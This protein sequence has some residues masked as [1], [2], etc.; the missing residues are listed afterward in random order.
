V[1]VVLVVIVVTDLVLDLDLVL[2]LDDGAR[3]P[4]PLDHSPASDGRRGFFS[5]GLG[6]MKAPSDFLLVSKSL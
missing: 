6:T 3:G 2:V 5:S 1:L 4:L